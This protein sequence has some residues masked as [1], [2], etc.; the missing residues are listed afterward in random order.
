MAAKKQ[1]RQD[2]FRKLIWQ[3]ILWASRYR[4]LLLIGSL[5]F[6]LLVVL[7]SSYF[8]LR[9]KAEQEAGTLLA[10]ADNILRW[11]SPATSEEE[12]TA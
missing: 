5:S 4:R 8:F 2:A 9:F 11:I 10:R 6:F 12:K 1:L 3:T 7:G